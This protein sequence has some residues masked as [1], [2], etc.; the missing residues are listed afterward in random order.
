MKSLQF[1]EKINIAQIYIADWES[2]SDG[3]R[4]ESILFSYQHFQL[5]V[6]LIT[7]KSN[8][9]TTASLIIHVFVILKSTKLAFSF[10]NVIF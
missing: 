10:C 2:D 9:L 1:R 8:V 7:N 3:V 6:N 4:R 5:D